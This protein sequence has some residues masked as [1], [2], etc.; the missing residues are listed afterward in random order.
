MRIYT[1]NGTLVFRP[2]TDEETD[3][4]DLLAINLKLGRPPVSTA[5]GVPSLPSVEERKTA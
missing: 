1:S 3:A 5:A 2:E 4:L